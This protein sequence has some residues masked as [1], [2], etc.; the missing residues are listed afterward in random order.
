MNAGRA[1][2]FLSVAL[3]FVNVAPVYSH[4]SEAS[5]FDRDDPVSVEGV[6]SK[7]EW[8]N[9]H[10]WYYVVVT[11]ENGEA[12]TW[13]FSGL[14]PGVLRRR[15]ITRDTL[16]V[17][18]VVRVTGNRARDGSN[19]AS[20]YNITFPDGRRVFTGSADTSQPQPQP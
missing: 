10:V 8:T 5:Q 6:V 16:K 18:D 12:T 15:G 17:G 3:F 7:L 14:P 4:H 13:G 20:G 11:D 2:I 9:P 19:N 1:L